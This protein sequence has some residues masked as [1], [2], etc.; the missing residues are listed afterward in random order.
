MDQ[1]ARGQATKAILD[2]VS[3]GK[4]QPG[5]KLNEADLSTQLNVSRNTLREAFATLTVR[6]IVTRIPH[7]GVF[8]AS[9]G[10]DEIRDFY[11]AR[12]ILEPA[13]LLWADHLDVAK[14]DAVVT[15]AEA[16]QAANELHLVG[17]ANQ[18]FHREIVAATGTEI[19]D[20]AMEQVLALMRLVFLAVERKYP[21]FHL[22]Y[23]AFNRRL[24]DMLKNGQRTE[25]AEEL[26][27]SLLETRDKITAQMF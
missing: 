18:E 2:A 13:A 12:A 1:S 4:Y 10:L 26:K 15:K 9:P 21:D 22:G 5:E 6:G 25:A 14:L 16:H 20:S 27:K 24:V 23:I 7:R 11:D 3:S 19:L 8:I 17:D